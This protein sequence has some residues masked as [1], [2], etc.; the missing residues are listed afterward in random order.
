VAGLRS[1]SSLPAVVSFRRHCSWQGSFSLSDYF[2]P[3]RHG[4]AGVPFAPVASKRRCKKERILLG[5]IDHVADK[6]AHRWRLHG[7]ISAAILVQKSESEPWSHCIS[8]TNTMKTIA[9][10]ETFESTY[11]LLVRSEET[12]R[13]RFEMLVYTV[14]IVCTTFAVAQ[15][16]HQTFIAPSGK[17]HVSTT[18]PAVSQHGV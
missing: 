17:A 11:A 14:L 4:S 9:N 2:V 18:M 16:G 1:F 7:E 8:Q 13:S 15:F 6:S 3:L 12:R 5:G 10:R